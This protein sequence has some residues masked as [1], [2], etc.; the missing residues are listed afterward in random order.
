MHFKLRPMAFFIAGSFGLCLSACEQDVVDT[1]I[2]NTSIQMIT[3]WPGREDTPRISPDG[4]SV[5]FIRTVEG[6]TDIFT[7]DIQSGETFRVTDNQASDTYPAWSPD[8]S[9]IAYR[10]VREGQHEIR[11]VGLSGNDDERIASFGDAQIAGLDWSPDGTRLAMT[12]VGPHRQGYMMWGHWT[13]QIID[14][15]GGNL[16]ELTSN[17]D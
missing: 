16:R 5:A 11:I 17:G 1:D 4:R 2:E 6:N 12:R 15:D 3:D 9:K 14:I 7:R 10:S 8:G 13:V